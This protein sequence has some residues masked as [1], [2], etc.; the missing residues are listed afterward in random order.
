MEEI[1]EEAKILGKSIIITDT[2]AIEA[3]QNYKNSIIIENTE[4]KKII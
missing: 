3:V 1:L 4:E 2:A